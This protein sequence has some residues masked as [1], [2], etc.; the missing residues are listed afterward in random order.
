MMGIRQATRE[1]GS[2]LK[3]L[4]SLVQGGQKGLAAW[5]TVLLDFT[6]SHNK[7]EVRHR[8]LKQIREE[9]DKIAK[10]HG[11]EG[12]DRKINESMDVP[13]FVQLLTRLGLDKSHLIVIRNEAVRKYEKQVHRNDTG[14]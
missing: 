1:F 7:H 10:K 5:S 14:R 2:G 4:P 11:R 9:Y 13:E 8:I 3:E 6:S 12:I